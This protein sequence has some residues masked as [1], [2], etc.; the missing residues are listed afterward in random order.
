MKISVI[1]PV[2]NEAAIVEDNLRSL[3]AFLEKEFDDFEIVAVNDGS[4]DRSGEIIRSLEDGRIVYVGYDENR[5]KG[6]ALAEGVARSS[7]DIIVTTDCDLAY[8]TSVIVEAVGVM[9]SNEGIDLLIGSR[10]LAEDGFA[11]YP[12]IRKLASKVYFGFISVYTGISVSDSQCGF[13]CYRKDAA[14]KLFAYLETLGFAFDLEILIK[15][16]Y[17]GYELTEMPVKIINHGDSK[18]NVVKDSLKMLSDIRKI[19]KICKKGKKLT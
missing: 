7:G 3:E 4:R 9:T 13:K 12:F 14:K 5:G 6:G 11:N 1:I 17:A 2:Y 15:A 8:G 10:S 18:V 19:K 16:K